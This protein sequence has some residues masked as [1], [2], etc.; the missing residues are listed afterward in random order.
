LFAEV[1]ATA[2]RRAE[3]VSRTVTIAL[4]PLE[5]M[6]VDNTIIKDAVYCPTLAMVKGV[7]GLVAKA[8]VAPLKAGS[9]AHDA[10]AVWHETEGDAEKGMEAFDGAY[11]EWARRNIPSTDRLAYQNLSRVMQ[12]WFRKHED[13]DEL[14]YT[15]EWIERGFRMPL[16]K[17]VE[18]VGLCDVLGRAKSDK[19]LRVVEHKTT[20][21]VT[22]W[23]KSQFTALAQL[24][25]YLE[26][27][28]QELGETV[29]AAYVNAIEFRLISSSNRMCKDHGTEYEEC[30]PL[31][32]NHELFSVQ[33][34]AGQFETWKAAAVHQAKIIRRWVE[35]AWEE[36]TPKMREGDE[37]GMQ[38]VEWEAVRDVIA[39]TPMLGT[40]TGQ[41]RFCELQEFCD[42][43]RRHASLLTLQPWRPEARARMRE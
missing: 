33:R 40:F 29:V 11:E 5:P 2:G 16:V 27:A 15:V 19:T 3:A 6:V 24:T 36:L 25:G 42:V 4:R 7:L 41:C 22:A 39:T 30:G 28:T 43:G 12:S 38:E 37:E 35:F 31:H 9:A 21:A 10:L 20:G 13:F 18:F 8:E 1:S 32:C 17:G 23:W 14:P 26:G 34:R